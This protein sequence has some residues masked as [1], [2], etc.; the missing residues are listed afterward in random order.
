VQDVPLPELGR[1]SPSGV[2]DL[3]RNEG[4]VKGGID[5]DTAAVAVESIRR[6]WQRGGPGALPSGPA[7]AA[8]GRWGRE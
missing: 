7:V 4:W 5:H 8:H 1:V 2:D 6:W 3:A